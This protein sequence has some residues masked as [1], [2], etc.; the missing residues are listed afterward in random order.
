M[1]AK[2]RIEKAQM[3]EGTKKNGGPLKVLKGVLIVPIPPL[4]P[5]S[6]K[7]QAHF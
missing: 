3:K 5:A 2:T 4:P 7:A 1:K 6:M